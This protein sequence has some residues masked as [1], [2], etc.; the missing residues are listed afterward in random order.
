[1]TPQNYI[2]YSIN[3]KSQLFLINRTVG[4]TNYMIPQNLLVLTIEMV[5][6]QC[7]IVKQNKIIILPQSICICFLLFFLEFIIVYVVKTWKTPSI[8][9]KKRWQCCWSANFLSDFQ[10]WIYR[11]SHETVSQPN[12][13]LIVDFH[14]SYCKA[15]STAV[16]S[17]LQN[18][19]F[20]FETHPSCF[21]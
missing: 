14:F 3:L 2:N 21:H 11:K 8:Y 6:N 18:S 4:S 5:P 1:M 10:A 7:C 12:N 20:N 17:K 13:Y 19:N 16:P 9:L 15:I